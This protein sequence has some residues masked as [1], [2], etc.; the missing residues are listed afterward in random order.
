MD[1]KDIRSTLTDE[2]RLRLEKIDRIDS[3]QKRKKVIIAAVTVTLIAFFALGTVFGAKYILSYEGTE[4]MPDDKVAAVLPDSEEKVLSEISSVK[5]A[6]SD[7]SAVRLYKNFKVSVPDD[8]VSVEGGSEALPDYIGF[9][10]K[11]L[12]NIIAEEKNSAGF[13]GKFGD[14]FS[15]YIPSLDFSPKDVVSA[16]CA[17][18]GDDESKLE[19]VVTF[20]DFSGEEAASLPFTAA[21]GVNNCMD[22]ADSIVKKLSGMAEITDVSLSFS[23]PVFTVKTDSAANRPESF[24]A[25]YVC[26]VEATAD[27]KDAFASLGSGKITFN[28][29]ETEIF[30][31]T[32]AG[33]KFDS[34]VYYIAKG[35][36]DELKYSVVSDLS[37]SEINVRWESSDPDVLSIDGNFYKAHKVSDKPV[38]VTGT[39]D[40]CGRTYSAKCTYYVRKELEDVKLSVKELSLKQGETASIQVEYKPADATVKAVRWF[41]EDESVARVD[42]NGNVTA[43]SKGETSVYLISEDGNYKRACVIEV[44]EG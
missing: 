34:D 7:C 36:S 29:E 12:V 2:E 35:D 27:F 1:E 14:D 23:K 16:T 32:F 22:T 8:S 19:Y 3:N 4:P 10:K 40:F 33:I 26:R 41:S 28:L 43:V 6:I 44:K 13:D 18:S 17:E 20:K 25:T 31:F 42:E 21:L 5:S 15:S 9:V 37:P 24:E 38:Y 39:F 11:S 30:D